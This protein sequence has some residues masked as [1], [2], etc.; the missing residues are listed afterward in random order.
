MSW[1]LCLFNCPS[2]TQYSIICCLL[3]SSSVFSFY[4]LWPFPITWISAGNADYWLIHTKLFPFL[5]SV[6]GY[7]M[8]MAHSMTCDRSVSV[9]IK[10]H[11][12]PQDI[13]ATSSHLF[14]RSFY[15]DHLA[16][17]AVPHTQIYGS[18]YKRHCVHCWRIWE[19]AGI[20][21]EMSCGQEGL[22]H[23]SQ[24]CV[25]I[26]FSWPRTEQES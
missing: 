6:Q 13:V 26:S 23:W 19:I 17:V 12:F 18:L 3:I 24:Q 9:E 10:A 5:L 22:E 20:V 4:C 8:R 7:L 1:R 15:S 14:L 2:T 25:M 21:T 11:D 16:L